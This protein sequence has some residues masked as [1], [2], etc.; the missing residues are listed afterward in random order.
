[1]EFDEAEGADIWERDIHLDMR[2]NEQIPQKNS[3]ILGHSFLFVVCQNHTS[4]FEG[5]K[6]CK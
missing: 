1:V 4:P 3:F 5:S 6:R 2:A